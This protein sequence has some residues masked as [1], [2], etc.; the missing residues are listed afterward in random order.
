[1]SRSSQENL[2]KLQ[3]WV[4]NSQK[5]PTCNGKGTVQTH[6][7][8]IYCTD[9]AEEIEDARQMASRK[10]PDCPDFNWVLSIIRD[11][12]YIHPRSTEM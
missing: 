7:P 11:L 6:R 5:C 10:C 2:E 4:D 8:T 1:M 3:M 9:S 12:Y